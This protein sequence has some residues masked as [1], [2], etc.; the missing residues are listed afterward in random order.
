MANDTKI[1]SD[2]RVLVGVSAVVKSCLLQLTLVA[3]LCITSCKESIDGT[4]ADQLDKKM[5]VITDSILV[6]GN[7]TPAEGSFLDSVYMGASG[8]GINQVAHKLIVLATA[9]D[10]SADKLRHADSAISLLENKFTASEK[11]AKLLMRAA[12]I[13]GGVNFSMKRYDEAL[14]D[15]TQLKIS[16]NQVSDSCEHT[17]YY[18][19]M[20]RLLYAQ[21]KLSDAVHYFKMVINLTEKCRPLHAYTIIQEQLGNVALCYDLVGM[22]DSAHYYYNTALDFIERNKNGYEPTEDRNA[23]IPLMKA[24]IEGNIGELLMTEG[25]YQEAEQYLL[26][27]IEV[28]RDKDNSFA[29]GNLLS[30]LKIYLRNNN[31]QKAGAVVKELEEK[32][33]AAPLTGYHAELY[34][35]R[36]EYFRLLGDYP[37]AYNNLMNSVAFRDSVSKRDWQFATMDVVREFENREQKSIN[38]VLR[39]DNELQRSYL[40]IFIISTVLALV[41]AGMVW[42]SLKRKSEYVA[43]LKKLNNEIEAKNKDLYDTLHSLEESHTENTRLL[44]TVAHDLRNPVGGIT[45]IAYTLRNKETSPELKQAL[46]LIHDAASDSLDLIKDLLT[47]K[48]KGMEIFKEMVD[49]GRLIQQCCQI[50]QLKAEEKR[51]RLKLEL[52][53]AK[54]PAHREKLYRVISNLISNAIKFSP[55]YS[56]IKVQLQ[57]TSTGILITVKDQGIGIPGHLQEKIFT[58]E[59]EGLRTGTTG[60]ESYGLGLAICQKIVKEH[61]GRIWF[62][63]EE[64]KGTAFFVSLPAGDPDIQ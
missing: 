54:V 12:N 13:R 40:L 34:K 19:N 32:V 10:A 2:Y 24:V 21:G 43:R 64:G 39:K 22:F 51:Q 38:E 53:Q 17:A 59:P 58:I 6:R 36:A 23:R 42:Y 11:S 16:M 28:T 56:D 1:E 63:S 27:S 3:L 52:E 62:E 18:E 60:E 5:R 35:I 25:K 33:E 14:R 31:L 8:V 15:Y 55:E 45:T 7:L 47:Y 57:N 4:D 37:T 41:I 48:K 29:T 49:L 20:A 26:K 44:R 61:Q 30:L 9:S 46:D 50:M